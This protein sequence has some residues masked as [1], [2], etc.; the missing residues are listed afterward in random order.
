MLGLFLK[1]I[2]Y[3][4]INQLKKLNNMTKAEVVN[5]IV[6]KTGA[7]KLV[8]QETL[9]AFFT[10]AKDS[11]QNGDNLY[12]RGFGSFVLQK[13]AQKIA[14]NIRR[15]TQIVI[16]EHHYPKFK[17]SKEFL[18]SVKNSVPNK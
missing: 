3:L 10:V 5:L 8:V 4:C 17:P 14:R 11:L 9:D 6:E 13:R 12:F 18:L 1:L 15:N 7:E 16:E 2:D